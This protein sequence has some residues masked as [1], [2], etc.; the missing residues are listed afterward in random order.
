M[1]R[2]FT[3]FI[4]L[5]IA[6]LGLLQAQM[7]FDFET[8]SKTDDT[9]AFTVPEP[10]SYWATVNSDVEG[11]A[12]YGLPDVL[13]QCASSTDAKNGFYAA[14]MAAKKYTIQT[15]SPTVQGWLHTGWINLDPTTYVVTAD[16]R[17]E[18]TTKYGSMSGW[19]KYETAGEDSCVFFA[20]LYSADSIVLATAMM[21]SGASAEYT[22]FDIP[23]EYADTETDVTHIGIYISC[24][25]ST[26]TSGAYA[27]VEGSVL[28]VD[29]LSLNTSVG[30]ESK[31]LKERTIKVVPL[32]MG[33]T[34]SIH[35]AANSDI[36]IFSIT[37]RL[38]LSLPLN[39]SEE[40]V[41]I[42]NL[43]QGIYLY[44]ITDNNQQIYTGKFF[45]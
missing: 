32:N 14:E 38:V 25:N 5:S 40:L 35:N 15:F 20:E 44:R 3:L 2:I 7:L 29:D 9:L 19:Y 45:K 30:V 37:G 1:K 18:N 4:F 21:K 43:D 31:M 13:P 26:P 33:N 28:V 23:F 11:L 27:G 34:L 42:G 22:A 12:A 10:H 41:S 16:L 6:G 24:S 8:W 17:V 36:D 39:S